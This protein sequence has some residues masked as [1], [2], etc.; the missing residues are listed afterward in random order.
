MRV[1]D[2]SLPLDAWGNFYVVTS[3]AAATLVG[4]LFVVITLAA[5][6]RPAS[7]VKWIRVYLTP[8]VT[9]FTSVLLLAGALTF[10]TQS[11][12]SV[13]VCCCVEGIAGVVYALW[14]LRGKPLGARFRERG[15]SWYYSLLPAA[16]FGVLV[17]GGA[18]L[19]VSDTS[20][21]LTLVAVSMLALV[22][23]AL[24]N[25]WAIAVTIIS[26]YSREHDAKN[27]G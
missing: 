3:A 12:L 8:T 11:R 9:Y 2:G 22:T 5:E 15:D 20:A 14:L 19:Y 23:L 27:R 4:L 13:T 18:T 26:P 16:A 1:A 25:S 7:E 24:R 10:P 6:R 17:G 21:G